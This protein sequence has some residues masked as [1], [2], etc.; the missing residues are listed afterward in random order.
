MADKI[1]VLIVGGGHN[2]LVAGYYLAKA[3]LNVEIFERRAVPGGAAATEELWPGFLFNTCAHSI[4]GIHPKLVRDLQL[5]QRGLVM[6]P[7]EFFLLPYADDTYWMAGDYPSPRNRG[8]NLSPQERQQEEQYNAFNDS[9]CSIFAPYRLKSPPSLQEVKDRVAGT[10]AAEVLEK[11]LTQRNYQIQDEFLKTETLKSRHAIDRAHVARDPLGLSA[12]YSMIQ[13]P[14]E[15]TGETPPRGYVRGGVYELTKILVEAATQAG[16]K[17]HLNQPVGNFIVEQGKVQGVKL[18]DGSEIRAKTTISNLDP[19]RTFLNL[20]PSE[21]LDAG[22][23]QRIEG[24]VSQNSCCKFLG[25]ISELPQWKAWDG[26]SE[27]P[28]SGCVIFGLTRDDIEETYDSL[29]AGI[30]P[31]KPVISVSVPSARDP[32]LTQPGYHTVS[33]YIYPM[34]SKLANES[35]DDARD[36][37]A[38]QMID[39][40][41][42]YAPNFRKSLVNYKLRTPQDIESD[43]GMTDGCIWHIQPDADQMFWNRPLPELAA[44][45]APLEGLYMCGAGQHPGGDI[46]GVPG[47]NAA[48]KI[49][50]DLGIDSGDDEVLTNPLSPPKSGGEGIPVK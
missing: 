34:P 50:Q 27:Q 35:W 5:F 32:S 3:G 11:A 26:P 14:D 40:I 13:Y 22:F 9:L 44:Y 47:H 8:Y 29:D 20:M 48:H 41:T 49:L 31:K 30:P 2:G 28:S 1:D 21:H 4:Y 6:L 16:A 17:I 19:K 36:R 37:V 18:E 33:I 38:E 45:K 23:R 10:P 7:R 43:N 15:K 25:V 12:V 39:R 46:T 42:E 24:L